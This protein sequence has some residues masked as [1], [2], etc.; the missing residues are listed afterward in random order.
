MKPSKFSDAQKTFMLKQGEERTSVA[1]ICRKSG[2]GHS[3]YFVC[4]RKYRGLLPHGIRRLKQ[5]ED[6]TAHP[7]LDAA[8]T[9]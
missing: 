8:R 5:L 3:A 7:S 2:G 6:E 9:R 1:E 4:K